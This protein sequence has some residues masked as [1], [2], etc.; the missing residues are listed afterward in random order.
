MSFVL[1]SAIL[2]FQLS[3]LL[4]SFLKLSISKSSSNRSYLD[5]SASLPL[6]SSS[7]SSSTLCFGGGDFSLGASFFGRSSVT[8]LGGR[9]DSRS[10]DESDDD[11]EDVCR[12]RRLLLGDGDLLERLR[13]RSRSDDEDELER[14]ERDLERER[15]RRASR[16]PREL[17]VFLLLSLFFF[18]RRPNSSYSES[19][20]TGSLYST[21]ARSL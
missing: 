21:L 2:T 9:L 8:L 13:R 5:K 6:S 3:I 10:L 1:L 18:L 20:E 11:D 16:E 15:E 7:S 12:R 19:D 14:D 4:L 17:T